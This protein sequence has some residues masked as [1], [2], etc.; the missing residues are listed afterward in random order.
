LASS[1]QFSPAQQRLIGALGVAYVVLTIGPAFFVPPP[2]PGG[3]PLADIASYYVGHRSA[4]LIA[5][6]TGLLA[7]PIGFGFFAGQLLTLRGDDATSRWLTW[8]ALLSIAATLSVAA[9]QGILA[10]AVPYVAGRATPGELALL[11]DVTQVGFSATFPLE[12]GYFVGAGLL[13][14]RS[15]AIPRWL[16]YGAFVVVLAALAA[17]FGIIATSG[18]SAAGGPVTLV[19]LVAGLLWWLIVSLLLLV[20]PAS[21]T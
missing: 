11:A 1:G 14:F 5:G 17:S 13:G 6:W 9:M 19:A 3:A 8:M 12:I 15:R 18:P 10:L 2:P 4:L 7:F 21:R 20:R 16:A